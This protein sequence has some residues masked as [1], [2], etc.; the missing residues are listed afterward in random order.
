[1]NDLPHGGITTPEPE[2]T[3]LMGIALCEGRLLAGELV[4]VSDID[5]NI[6]IGWKRRNQIDNGM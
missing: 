1:M 3:I 2:D 4:R 6:Q 5:E